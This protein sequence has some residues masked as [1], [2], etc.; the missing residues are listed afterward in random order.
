MILSNFR[1]ADQSGNSK[2]IEANHTKK[3]LARKTKKDPRC[4]E[5]FRSK[6]RSSRIALIDHTG[7]ADR[8]EHCLA[9]MIVYTIVVGGDEDFTAV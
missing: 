1:F 3:P 6:L 7:L 8:E 4:R 2:T 5:P 9:R